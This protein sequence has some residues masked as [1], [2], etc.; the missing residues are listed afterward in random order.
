ML[1]TDRQ[2]EHQV[3]NDQNPDQNMSTSKAGQPEAENRKGLMP[4]RVLFRERGM[5]Q[6]GEVSNLFGVRV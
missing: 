2:H 3:T 4:K 6:A 5:R 1:Y